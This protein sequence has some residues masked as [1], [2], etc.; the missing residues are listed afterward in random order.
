VHHHAQFFFPFEM[1]SDKLFLLG[2][3]G[4]SISVSEPPF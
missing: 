4:T 2:W 1:R 3:P